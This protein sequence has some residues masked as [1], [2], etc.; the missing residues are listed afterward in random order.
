MVVQGQGTTLGPKDCQNQTNRANRLINKP[1][2]PVHKLEHNCIN[3]TYTNADQLGNKVNDLNLYLENTEIRP[4][5]IAITEVKPKNNRY[6]VFP[7]E[8][9]AEVDSLMH[10]LLL[11]HLC[12]NNWDNIV[13]KM[14]LIIFN[15][16]YLYGIVQQ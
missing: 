2:A 3:V 16:I 10:N 13:K 7:A 9:G 6:P 12:Q 15:G 8:S 11:K 1:N 14:K 5:I 4:Q